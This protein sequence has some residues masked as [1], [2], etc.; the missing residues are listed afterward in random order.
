MSHGPGGAACAVPAVP[1]TPAKAARPRAAA[2]ATI[3]RVFLTLGN[4]ILTKGNTLREVK[5]DR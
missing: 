1:D 4:L 2:M 3:E 5:C